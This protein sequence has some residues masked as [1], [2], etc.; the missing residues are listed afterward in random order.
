MREKCNKHILRFTYIGLMGRPPRPPTRTAHWTH[1]QARDM[2]EVWTPNNAPKAPRRKN[3]ATSYQSAREQC[4]M[5][6]TRMDL[7]HGGGFRILAGLCIVSSLASAGV[8]SVLSAYW[9][10]SACLSH[11]SSLLL[12]RLRLKC[13][14]PLV[15]FH[16]VPLSP[17]YCISSLP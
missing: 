5:W 8:V 15:I 4:S 12:N 11:A 10:P 14:Q 2:W 7:R 13:L 16:I 1:L 17:T 6:R 9:L 3:H